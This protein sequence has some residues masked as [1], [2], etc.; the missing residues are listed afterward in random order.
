MYLTTSFYKETACKAGRY[1]RF[2]RIFKT[3]F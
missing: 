3:E 2:N 1:C